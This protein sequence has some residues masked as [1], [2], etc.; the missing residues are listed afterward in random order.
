MNK[1][2]KYLFSM[3]IITG[4]L[5]SISTNNWIT[6]WIGLEMNLLSM[7]PIMKSKNKLSSESMMKY[8]ITQALASAII[9]FSILTFMMNTNEIIFMSNKTNSTL[10]ELS[11]LMKMGAAPLHFWLPE[12]ISGLEWINSLLILTW[13]KIAPM[14]L[15]TYTNQTSILMMTVIMMSSII[16]GIYGMNQTCLRKIMAYSSINHMGWML[17]SLMI[18]TTAWFIYFLIYS[19]MNMAIMLHLNSTNIYFL[20][21][22]NKNS[23]KIKLNNYIFSLNLMSLGGL[24]PFIGFMPKWLTIYFMTSMHMYILTTIL[25]LTTMISLYVYMRIIFS[26]L[27]LASSESM[28]KTNTWSMISMFMSNISIIGLI[29]IIIMPETL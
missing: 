21:Q 13:Q 29:I 22:I 18:S 20:S 23:F 1:F 27:I 3:M 17:A 6:A 16:G 10:L 12:V 19:S 5:I 26:S 24:P 11:L 14:I 8:F 7:M 25:I 2:Y 9:L 15:L 4:T 28:V